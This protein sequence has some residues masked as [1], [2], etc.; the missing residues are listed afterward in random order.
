MPNNQPAAL[1]VANPAAGRARS[2]GQAQALAQALNR[3]GWTAKV[4]L[5]DEPGHAIQL[6]REAA[7]THNVVVAV[8][9]DGTASEAAT[10]L[11]LAACA[12]VRLAL[13]P[14]GS[15]NDIAHQLGI[16]SMQQALGAVVAGHARPVDVI[17]ITRP[18]AR[19]PTPRFALSFVAAGLAAE[20][21]HRTTPWMKRCWGPQLAYAVG[22]LRALLHYRAP[23]ARVRLDGKETEDRF[24]HVC[25]GN[26]EW[27]G[28]RMMRISPGARMDDG[29]LN[30]CLIRAKGRREILRNLPRL[31]RGT[32]PSQPG[33]TYLEGATLEVL[34]GVAL[35]LQIDGTL[36]GVTPI[37]CRIRPGALQ[38]AIPP[39]AAPP[40]A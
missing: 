12:H 1:L 34:D 7:P 15:G 35:P 17:E 18:G 2:A 38:V 29:R 32:F 3:Q 26:A 11:L 23:L 28:G 8:G 31:L 19:D 40:R 33:V 14:C 30:L 9:G 24:L 4:R 20:L 36:E 13:L 27:A 10:G 39:H 21:I 16:R 37:R 6:A 22:F 25:A 5:T